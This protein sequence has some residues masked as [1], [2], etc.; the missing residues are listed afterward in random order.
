MACGKLLEKIYY[1]YTS[2]PARRCSGIRAPLLWLRTA[3]SLLG[4]SPNPQIIHWEIW[5]CFELFYIKKA[6]SNGKRHMLLVTSSP[7]GSLPFCFSRSSS[8]VLAMRRR[9]FLRLRAVCVSL[10]TSC[11]WPQVRFAGGGCPPS[12]TSPMVTFAKKVRDR[13]HEPDLEEKERFFYSSVEQL[14]RACSLYWQLILVRWDTIDT[15]KVGFGNFFTRLIHAA[16]N[17]RQSQTDPQKSE[18]KCPIS[19]AQR[20]VL[21][22]LGFERQSLVC[23]LKQR[24][25]DDPEIDGLD[26]QRKITNFGDPSVKQHVGGRR[27]HTHTA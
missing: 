4:R 17:Y 27:R 8:K 9:A 7:G 25:F 15:W 12:K 11:R 24:D 18:K 2:C 22:R 16:S 14:Q 10:L 1:I 23:F 13:D 3:S 20:S 26:Q 21:V 5:L 19:D 6:F